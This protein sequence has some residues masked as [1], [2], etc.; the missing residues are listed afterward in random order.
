M[1]LELKDIKGEGLEQGYS[2]SLSEFPDLSAIAEGGGPKFSEPLVFKLRLQRTGTFVEVDGCLDA[3]VTLKCGRCLQGFELP[4]SELFTLTFVPCL[5][6]DN[7]TEEEV[8]LETGDLG[9]ITYADEV[10]ELQ[11]PLQEQ[12]LMAVPISPVCQSSCKGLCPECGT[13]LNVMRCGCVRTP[14]NSKFT[15]LANIDCKKL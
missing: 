10:L 2:C 13:D 12:L 7:E 5:P 8:E 11:D 15:V 1:R 6:G 9:L 4:L 3:V 14:F